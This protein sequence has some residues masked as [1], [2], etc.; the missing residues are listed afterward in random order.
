MYKAR[1]WLTTMCLLIFSSAHASININVEAVEKTVVFLYAADATGDAVD[2]NKP[3]GTGFLVGVPL[4]SDAKRG[5]RVLVTARHIVD[6]VW[7][8][9]PTV[10]NAAAIYARLNKKSYNSESGDK[11]VDFVRI[12]LSKDGNPTWKHHK[13]DDIDAVVVP[14]NI[15]ENAFDIA[16][17]PVEF[18][19]T[20]QEIKYESIGDPVMSAGLLP[21]LTGK[22]R[23]Y[24]IF[25]FGQ[26]SNIPS[27][28]VETHCGQN[29]PAFLV[30]VWL[31]AANLVSGNSG[32]PIFHIPL[33][34]SGVVIGGTRPMLLGVQSIS[35]GGADV[36]GMTPISYVYEILEQI[37]LPDA[38]LHR[39][40][41]P[42]NPPA[43]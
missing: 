22:S 35:Y 12:E 25:K 32:S 13:Y 18:F 2:G 41:P 39:G 7:A 21:S 34:G 27:E 14:V 28:D 15:N 9:C 38:D 23:N 4:Q 19:P 5:Y 36:A 17:V 6:P 42:P 26:I 40:L 31:I 30:K 24:P 10:I 11:G 1:I 3:I 33:G 43:K 16:A 8:K 37:G 29:G 20:E